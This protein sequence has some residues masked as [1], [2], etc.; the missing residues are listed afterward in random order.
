MVTHIHKPTTIVCELW[1]AAFASPGQ[2]SEQNAADSRNSN[3]TLA[4]ALIKLKCE[5]AWPT[6]DI[7]SGCQPSTTQ[8]KHTHTH[9][10]MQDRGKH[11]HVVMLA[12]KQN[13]CASHFQNA[14]QARLWCK[15]SYL[16]YMRSKVRL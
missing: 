9:T 16:A 11:A 1:E 13:S 2:G 8:Q 4:K 15:L 3:L 12:G 14:S 6:P 5:A 7:P 10:Q